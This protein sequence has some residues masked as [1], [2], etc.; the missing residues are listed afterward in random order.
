MFADSFRDAIT[1]LSILS[2]CFTL[3][4]ATIP[5]LTITIF[6][7]L[8]L[9]SYS[10]PYFLQICSQTYWSVKILIYFLPK[11]LKRAYIIIIDCLRSKHS[12]INYVSLLYL[13]SY[14]A[15][16]AIDML[17]FQWMVPRLIL[18]SCDVEPNPGPDTFKFYCWNPS[19]IIAHDFILVTLRDAYH[20]IHKYDLLGIVETHLNNNIDQERL[21]LKGFDLI[22]CNHASNIKKSGVRLYVKESLSKTHRPDM[23]TLS[24]CIVC[25]I[26]QIEKN[27][28]CCIVQ[29]S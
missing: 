15:C 9:L 7:L 5:P 20:S 29:K 19:S 21:V 23:T 10:E 14:A 8:C 17:Y 11:L 13:Q 28:F 16:L 4:S 27:I 3:I 18:L 26:V 2:F 12:K 6:S 1:N 25:E 24:E 22:A